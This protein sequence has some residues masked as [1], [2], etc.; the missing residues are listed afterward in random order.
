M[1][2]SVVPPSPLPCVDRNIPVTRALSTI[3]HFDIPMAFGYLLPTLSGRQSPDADTLHVGPR[4]IWSR[5]LLEDLQ[6]GT[7][8]VLA[9]NTSPD[10]VMPSGEVLSA[11][12]SRLG[13]DGEPEWFPYY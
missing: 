10:G 6:T 12:R 3:P 9:D 8:L 2:H 1:G 7:T 13:L 4:R 11:L 5:A